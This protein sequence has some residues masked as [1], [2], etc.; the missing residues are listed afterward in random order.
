MASRKNLRV[1]KPD[2][3]AEPEPLKSI[4]DAA[5]T[6]SRLDEMKAIHR[7]VA[8]AV[9]DPNTP[10]RDLAALARRRLEIGREIEEI[11]AT[12][13]RLVELKAI[14]RRVAKAMDDPNTPPRDLAALSRLQLEIGR[15]IE[16]IEIAEDVEKSVVADTDDEIWDGTGF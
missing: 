12:G 16:A 15:E 3:K 4:L 9:D 10:P 2:E 8:K 14:R 6:G 5:E 13:S 11:E 7:R 1:V